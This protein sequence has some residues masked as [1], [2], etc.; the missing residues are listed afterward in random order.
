MSPA[1]APL[2][3]RSLIAEAVFTR[4]IAAVR[5]TGVLV[6]SALVT[7]APEG[8]VPVAVAVLSTVPAST[9]AWVRVWVLPVQVADA[10][11]ASAPEGQVMLG[12][13]DP[14]IGSCTVTGLRLTLP[15]L[16]TLKV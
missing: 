9:L 6:E 5:A 1:S 10:P 8:A 16:V 11:G 2:E 12:A 4:S 3:S 15:V 14:N 7:F 13:V